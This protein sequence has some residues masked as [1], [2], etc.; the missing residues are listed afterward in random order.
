MDDSRSVRPAP[1]PGTEILEAGCLVRRVLR[2]V[3]DK[4]TPIVLYCLAGGVLRFSDFQHRIPDISKKM[5]TQVLRELEAAGLVERTVYPTA[6]PKTEYRL[7]DTGRRMHEPTAM[8]CQ[9]AH[10]NTLL[11]EEIEAHKS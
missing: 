6:P 3:G 11:L 8:L 5:L 2:I 9:W 1:S 10:E 4:W 7:T